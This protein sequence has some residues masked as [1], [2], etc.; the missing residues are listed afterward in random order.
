MR[1]R[2]IATAP[3]AAGGLIG[4]YAVAVG[5]GSRPLG[6]VVLAGFGVT[7][8]AIWQRRDGTGTTIA[9]TG[10]GLTA[11]ALSHVLGPVIGPWPAVLL[12]AAATAAACWTVSDSRHFSR[13]ALQGS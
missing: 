3:V 4:A 5:S 11:F 12:L 10:T 9:L 8:M 6:G 13:A 7:C 2:R 1:R